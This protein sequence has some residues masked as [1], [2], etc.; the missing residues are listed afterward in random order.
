MRSRSKLA[1]WALP[2]TLSMSLSGGACGRRTVD[3]SSP[4]PTFEIPNTCAP[5]TIFCE[6]AAELGFHDG[7]AYGRGVALVDVDGDGWTDVWRSDSGRWE[8][9][10]PLRSGLF[11]NM[12]D[13]RFEP[14]DVGIADEHV[15]MNWAGIFGDIDGDGAQDLVLLNGGYEGVHVCAVYRNAVR[16]T[17]RF[18]DVTTRSGLFTSASTWWSGAFADYDGDGDLDLVV[19]RAVD[20][21]DPETRK[22]FLY[23]NDG[24]GAFRDVTIEVGIPDIRGDLKNPVWLDYDRDGDQDLVLI[25]AIPA[26][27]LGELTGLYENRGEDGFVRVPTSVF[28]GDAIASDP[29]LVFAAAA[30][31]FDQDGWEDLYLGR[32]DSQDLVFRNRHDGT[33]EM[34]GAEIGIDAP[35]ELNTMG[36]G[37]G[38]M[39]G[40]GYPDVFVGPGDPQFARPPVVYCNRGG[41]TLGFER[42]D[43]DFVAGV[44][45]ARWHGVAF[46]DLNRDF[47]VD[48]VA[49]IGGFAKYDRENGTDTAEWFS[50]FVNHSAPQGGAVRLRLVG[51]T[52]PA[53]PLGAHLRLDAD[54]RVYH[55]LHGAQGF[56]SINDEWVVLPMG[57]STKADAHV[58][59]PSGHV[60]IFSVIAGTEAVL[61]EGEGKPSA[62]SRL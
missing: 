11:R 32:W 7:P 8:D 56:Q 52:S 54:R 57:E 51:T 22:V 26:H 21:D 53:V 44:P 48:V 59:W 43:D 20:D 12:G 61:V 10:K 35:S 47:R 46:G 6:Q 34:L 27:D 39:T 5:G 41:S 17:G 18:E 60:E 15:D 33:F 45:E 19:V 50:V 49:N 4:V 30:A 55:T 62:E 25:R 42:C 28:P 13:G 58:H 40:D 38:D 3:Q 16:E 14:W 36:L 1:R 23:E 2:L 9:G 24:R 31:D 29:I 37:V